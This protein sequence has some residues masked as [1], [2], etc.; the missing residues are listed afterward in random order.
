MPKPSGL[1]EV[2][3]FPAGGGYY[4]SV[5]ERMPTGATDVIAI[6]ALKSLQG[7]FYG[8]GPC[9]P[10]IVQ[11][12]AHHVHYVYLRQ[13]VN[14]RTKPCFDACGSGKWCI[15]GNGPPRRFAYLASSHIQSAM[16]EWVVR[17]MNTDVFA[18]FLEAVSPCPAS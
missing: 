12:L 11:R 5:W 9:P 7:D 13:H 6:N 16:R 2:E 1:Y 17:Q 8:Y 3:I 14:G 15:Y 10:D 4:T 18:E